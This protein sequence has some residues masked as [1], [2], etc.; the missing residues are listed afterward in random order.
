M[1][2]LPAEQP[3]AHILGAKPQRFTNMIEGKY[4]ITARFDDPILSFIE[5]L[6]LANCLRRQIVLEAVN[7]I[8]QERQHESLLRL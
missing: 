3:L 4:P 6:L 8:F 5:K 2:F 1:L 7:R